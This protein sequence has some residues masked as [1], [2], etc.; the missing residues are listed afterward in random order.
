MRLRLKESA[1]TTSTGRRYPGS[2]R[3][4]SGRSAH[5]ISTRSISSIS[6]RSPF[7]GISVGRDQ[8]GIYLRGP[9]RIHFIQAFRYRI[10][11][12][13]VQELRNRRSVQLTSRYPEA[14]GS[15]F[16]QTEKVVGYREVSCTL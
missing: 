15:S 16:C 6:T 3:R 12:L 8:C 4:G 9:A 5:Q 14:T 2:E 13:P 1:W 11:L 10:P 7:R